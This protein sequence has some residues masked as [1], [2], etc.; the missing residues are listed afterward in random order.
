MAV[1]NERGTRGSG[2]SG[3]KILLLLV[4]VLLVTR[5]LCSHYCFFSLLEE[6]CFSFCFVFTQIHTHTHVNTAVLS[7]ILPDFSMHMRKMFHAQ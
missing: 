4:L 6:K 7:Y 2:A 5:P 1:G 3:N